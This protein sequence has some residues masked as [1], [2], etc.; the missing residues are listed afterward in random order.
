MLQMENDIL[1]G[2]EGLVHHLVLS[3][4][5]PQVS[6][7]WVNRTFI[8]VPRTEWPQDIPINIMYGC[9]QTVYAWA[10]GGKVKV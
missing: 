8:T 4:C 1:D 6:T 10:V 2:N 7:D 3:A 9:L 5:G